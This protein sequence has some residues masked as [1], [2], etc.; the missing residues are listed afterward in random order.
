LSEKWEFSAKYTYTTGRPYTP[1]DYI[2]SQLQNR[3]IYDI[4]MINSERIPNYQRLDVRIDY[5]ANFTS[6]NLVAYFE[7][8]NAFDRKNISTFIWNEK[9]NELI[10]EKQWPL[11]PNFGIKIEM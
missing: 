8:Q 4:A 2:N 10:G 9:T 5:R 3:Q 1:P 11:M 6:W 7:V